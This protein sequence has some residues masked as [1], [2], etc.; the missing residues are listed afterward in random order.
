ML[1]GALVLGLG[2]AAAWDRALLRAQISPRTIE[3]QPAG[4]ALC[5]FANGEFAVLEP[6][7]GTAVTRYWVALRLRSPRRRSLFVAAGMLA[8]ESMRLLRLWVLWGKLP[9]VASRQLTA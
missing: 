7:G 8:P 2:A 1:L 6:L 4:T 9:S 5:R 3:I